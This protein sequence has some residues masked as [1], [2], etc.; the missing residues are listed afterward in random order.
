MM[1]I[2]I[3]RY[4]K[5]TAESD[6]NVDIGQVASLPFKLKEISEFYDCFYSNQE[7]D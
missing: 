4:K 6:H 1:M 7:S 5:K 2:L 3:K